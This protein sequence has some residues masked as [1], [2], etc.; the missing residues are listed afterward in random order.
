MLPK[1][2]DCYLKRGIVTFSGFS[3]FF[4]VFYMR[5]LLK[6]QILFFVPYSECLKMLKPEKSGFLY[7]LLAKVPDP[8]NFFFGPTEIPEYSNCLKSFKY[9]YKYKHT[10]SHPTF[11]FLHRPHLYFTLRF[12][13]SHHHVFC[14]PQ[15]ITSHHMLSAWIMNMVNMN[16][17]HGLIY[18]RS[19]SFSTPPPASVHS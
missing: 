18:F 5:N 6:S 15:N 1:K 8:F 17:I 11:L 7:F 4:P 19:N 10:V 14:D 2:G 3:D 12:S 16:I 13:S 9:K